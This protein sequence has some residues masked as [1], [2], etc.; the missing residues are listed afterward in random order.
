MAELPNCPHCGKAAPVWMIFDVGDAASAEF[1]ADGVLIDVE[2]EPIFGNQVFNCS[3]CKR[4]RFDLVL[5]IDGQGTNDEI[6]YLDARRPEV[7]DGK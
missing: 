2:Y 3:A 7:S 5:E 1:D 6:W 4:W